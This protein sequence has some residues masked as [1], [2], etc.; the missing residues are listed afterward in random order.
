VTFFKR[1]FSADYRRAVAA[2]AAGDYSEAARA[3]ALAG[4]HAKV[5]E[6]H[7]LRAER[8]PS[9]EGRLSELRAAVRWADPDEPEGRA[10]RRRIARALFTW[11]K[12]SGVVSDADRAVVREAA[13]LFAEAGDHAGA[14]ECHEFIGDELQAAESYQ[15][16]GDLE[17]LESVL[18]REESRRRKKHRVTDAFDEYQLQLQAGER[19]L[20]LASIRTA[21]EEAG[22]AD[23]IAYRQKLEDLE[24][25]LLAEWK[26]TLKTP[27][28]QALYV[29]E[30]PLVLGR[31]AICHVALRDAGISR[32]HAE[33]GREGDRFLLRDLHSK[34]GTSLMSVALATG[35]A[36]AIE[37]EGDLGIGEHCGLAF[38]VRESR[39]ELE[40]T[41]GLDR[42]LRVIAS[43]RS[44]DLG[45]TAELSFVEGRPR[46]SVRN[47]RSFQ[48][49]GVHAGAPVQLIRGD[50]VDVGE[51][52]IEVV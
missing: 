51:L 30:F 49:N 46:I 8:A 22:E 29:G 20:A 24:A 19:D 28:G 9:P 35:S 26:I 17:K 45:S 47:G 23:K 12:Q 15:R 3:Y 34:N 41:R 6:M 39:L 11:A 37:G 4:E 2:E 40:V 16:A 18:Q 52:R 50:V 21:V 13:A 7:L 14:G 27:A 10:V 36:V 44:I 5:A 38:R 43:A 31:E 1:M 33:V 32:R 25:R 48:L 42:G